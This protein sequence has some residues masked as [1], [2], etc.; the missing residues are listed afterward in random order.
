MAIDLNVFYTGTDTNNG[1]P[2]PQGMTGTARDAHF[3][4]GRL[5]GELQENL[6]AWDVKAAKAATKSFAY[7]DLAGTAGASLSRA[8]NWGDNQ[9][10][11]FLAAY[12]RYRPATLGTTLFFD[13]ETGNGG[14]TPG[15][16]LINQA[17]LAGALATIAKAGYTPGIYCSRATWIAFF[18][19]HW[20]PATAFVLWLAGTSCPKTAQ[21]AIAAW[22][23]LSPLGGQAPSIWQYSVSGGGCPTS[24][25]Q[26]WNVTPYG[27]WREGR[28]TPIPASG[29]RTEQS[30]TGSTPP[31]STP[32][33]TAQ[34]DLLDVEH[35]LATATTA[36]KAAQRTLK[37]LNSSK[38]A[39]N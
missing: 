19:V 7:W 20:V 6:A 32:I 33:A 3:Y 35:A 18:G 39:M 21:D 14:W 22:H 12:H 38:G 8:M 26:D 31:S 23:T 25:M 27:G 29:H 5:G 17:V 4:L 24:P 37:Q 2:F 9:A 16:P 34:A 13:V 15:H 30:A 11:A 10:L 36:L 1:L 28:W